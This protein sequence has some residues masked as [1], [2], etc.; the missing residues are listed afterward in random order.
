ML[1]RVKTK[2]TEKNKIKKLCN[3]FG[4]RDQ[5][6]GDGS[7]EISEGKGHSSIGELEKLWLLLIRHCC[8]AR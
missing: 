4:V 1:Q 5:K 7:T 6:G 2:L 8:T 3:T